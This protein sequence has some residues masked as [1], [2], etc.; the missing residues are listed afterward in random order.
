MAKSRP[1]LPYDHRQQPRLLLQVESSLD[2]VAKLP[3]LRIIMMG[4]QVGN[5]GP[6]S[7]RFMA[8][9]SA[10][11][12]LRHPEKDI[13]R[14]SYPGHEPSALPDDAYQTLM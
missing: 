1:G 6:A 14:I 5:W 11:L 3:N 9:L 12:K 4:K 10:K 7:M 13:L 2:F 8:E